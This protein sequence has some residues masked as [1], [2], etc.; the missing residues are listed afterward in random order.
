MGR[1]DLNYGMCDMEG[2][3][4]HLSLSVP[5]FR[6]FNPDV[7]EL[8]DM[9]KQ[10]T[11]VDALAAIVDLEGF[12][13]FCNQIDPQLVVPD[14][15]HQLLHWLFGRV[16]RNFQKEH[17]NDVVILWA[18]FPFYAKFL[19]DGVLFLWDTDGLGQASLGNII[20]NLRKLCR[21]YD[22]EF[23]TEAQKHFSKVPTRLRCGV[24]R[25]QVIPVGGG[26]DFVGSCINVASR[27]QKIGNLS[28]AF[29]RKGIHL[30]QCFGETS[31]RKFVLKKMLLR[32]V[33]EDELIFVSRAEYEALPEEE[34]LFFMDP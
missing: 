9:S 8:G 26:T 5:E 29:S 21:A 10:G 13:A 30:D 34:K 28:F 6:R 7:L 23:R 33:G 3:Y 32:G 17:K 4:K 19:G 16:S 27:L 1:I 31:R 14:F 24:A 12:T 20:V 2:G 11:P 15:L 25:G 18:K 22:S